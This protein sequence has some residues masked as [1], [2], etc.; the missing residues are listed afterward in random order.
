MSATAQKK[1][2]AP[3]PGSD[4][5]SEALRAQPEAGAGGAV[6]I[7][8]PTRHPVVEARLERLAVRDDPAE[9]AAGFR[10]RLQGWKRWADFLGRTGVCG[11][12]CELKNGLDEVVHELLPVDPVL[13]HELADSFL[14][15]DKYFFEQADD[16]D[17]AIGDAVRAGCRLWLVL[18]G[19]R[20]DGPAAYW[21]ER[22]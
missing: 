18:P 7:N 1:Q 20:W 4:A 5:R 9:L 14:Q 11:L 17:G 15:A 21:V 6:Q 10:S 19:H 22:S 12:S 8:W 13:A 2:P 3:M 16:S